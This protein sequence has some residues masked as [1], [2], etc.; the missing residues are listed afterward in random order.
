M[1]SKEDISNKPIIEQRQAI[2]NA[3]NSKGII[4]VLLPNALDFDAMV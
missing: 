4:K 3:I 1:V 2:A